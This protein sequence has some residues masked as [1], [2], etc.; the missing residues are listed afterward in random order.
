MRGWAMAACVAVTLA[1]AATAGA[2]TGVQVAPD[3]KSNLISKDV[4]D[5]RWAIHYDLDDGTIT[6]NVFFPAG[7][8]PLFVWCEERSSDGN[9][10]T[11]GCWGAGKC[12]GAPCAPTDWSFIREVALPLQFFHPP[13]AIDVP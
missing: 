11:I 6:G 10:L 12:N 1:G 7:G 8:D 2:Q 9:E 4:G 5:E 3:G 13:G